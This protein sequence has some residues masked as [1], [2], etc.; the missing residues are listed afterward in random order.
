MVIYKILNLIN[1]KCYVGSTRNLRARSNEHWWNLTNNQHHSQYL[2]HAFNKLG[3]TKFTIQV[4]ENVSSPKDLVSREQFYI[5][6]LKPAYNMCK[7]AGNCSGLKQTAAHIE[8]KRAKNKKV[9]LQLNLAGKLLKEWDGLIDASV[10]LG[11]SKKV[12]SDCCRGRN[13]TAG[14]FVF[15]LKNNPIPYHRKSRAKY[16]ETQRAKLKA[17]SN[18]GTFEIIY[19]SGKKK[20][21][22]NLR[23]FCDRYGLRLQNMYNVSSGYR[24]HYKGYKVERLLDKK[25]I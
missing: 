4:I 16:T 19:P 18:V 6:L 23:K 5:N 17:Q 13:K 14:G 20:T 22:T 1:G 9:V 2:Q 11:I 15:Q 21:I 25:D 12:I 24:K 8:K 3:R 7:V 10:A